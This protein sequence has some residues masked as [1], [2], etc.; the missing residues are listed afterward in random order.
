MCKRFRFGLITRTSGP[1]IFNQT[2]TIRQIVSRLFRRTHTVP[3]LPG[4]DQQ[5]GSFY[6]NAK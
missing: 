1:F 5:C 2:L 3:Y 6:L 4:M